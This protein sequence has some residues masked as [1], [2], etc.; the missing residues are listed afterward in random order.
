MR[1]KMQSR[2][3]WFLGFM[4]AFFLLLLFL[5]F[6]S[7]VAYRRGLPRVATVMPVRTE[8]YENGRYLYQ[9]PQKA[10][11]KSPSD[12]QWVIYTARSYQDVLGERC[13]VTKIKVRIRQ[14]ENGIALVDG[15]VK[16]EP[17]ITEDIGQLKDGEAVIIRDIVADQ[18]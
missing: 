10:L 14:E 4:L 15:I 12:N 2:T 7:H 13:L 5:T 6:Y 3:K 17:V 18:P 8:N 9:I 16:E 11:Q 1:E